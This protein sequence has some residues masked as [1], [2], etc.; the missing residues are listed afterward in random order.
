MKNCCLLLIAIVFSLSAKAQ[1]TVSPG[2]EQPN[3]LQFSVNLAVLGNNLTNGDDF[4]DEAERYERM[5]DFRG[6]VSMFNRAANEYQNNR[7]FSRYGTALLR[8]SNAHL[9]LSNYMEAEQV[10]LSQA[11]KNYTKIHSKDGQMAS[12]QQLGKI[13]LAA[14]KLTQALW[15]YTQQGILAQQLNNKAAYIESVLGIA[16]IKIRKKDYKLATKDLNTAELL[17]K[18]A[19]IN[20]FNQQIRNNR[21]LIAEKTATKKAN[22]LI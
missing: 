20:Q 8:L 9:S 12:Y 6:A 18:N 15:F 4:F 3:S 2:L 19:N 14:N 13:Y 1:V 11:L 17:S 22:N 10:I 7:K 21:A 16:V 5:G